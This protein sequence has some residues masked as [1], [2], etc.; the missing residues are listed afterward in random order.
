MSKIDKKSDFMGKIEKKFG[1][2]KKP[3]EDNFEFG[4]SANKN[5]NKN[6]FSGDDYDAGE[7]DIG[8]FADENPENKSGFE[9]TASSA[10]NQ[11][12]DFNAGEGDFA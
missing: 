11:S 9:N 2:K 4:V 12:T 3:V 1:F 7:F 8:F 6:G 5:Q 10:G